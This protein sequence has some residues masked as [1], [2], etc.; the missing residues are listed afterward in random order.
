MP[1]MAGKRG[2][3]VLWSRRFFPELMPLDGDVG[4][5]H[6]IAKYSEAVVEVPVTGTA[7]LTDIDTPD[8]LKADQGRART[9]L[10]VGVGRHR[11]RRFSRRYSAFAGD[12]QAA[13]YGAAWRLHLFVI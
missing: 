10:I 11:A 2:N 4:A 7:A 5:R 12:R 1:V 8:A 9:P 3:P 13:R 6:L